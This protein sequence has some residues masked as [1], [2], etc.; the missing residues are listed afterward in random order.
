MLILGGQRPSFNIRQKESRNMNS[1]LINE[2][3]VSDIK[4]S[5]PHP[6]GRPPRLNG[7][8]I[9]QICDLIIEGKTIERAARLSGV[10]ATSIYRWLAIGKQGNSEP[11]Y[12]E[13]V[14]R[15]REATECSEFELLQSM[16]I[17]GSNPKNW[18]ANAWLLER[19]FPEKYGNSNKNK[20]VSQ[21]IGK[22]TGIE[23][24]LVVAS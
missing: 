16:R 22:G 10:S 23:N 8:L 1:R 15:V 11:I 21:E 13:L 12:Q 4:S 17:S 20:L 18:R 19:R 14:E 6:V 5:R 3:E 9:E 7:E 24:H 2:L